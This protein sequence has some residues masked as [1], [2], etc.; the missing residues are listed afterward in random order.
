MVEVPVFRQQLPHLGVGAED[1]LRVTR[2]R[3]P[4]ERTDATAEHRANI[5]W[6]EA[7]EVEGISD[8]FLLRH[9]ADVVAVVESGRPAASE[10]EHPADVNRHRPLRRR[11]H[12]LRVSL[13]LLPPLGERPP[14]R[15]VAVERVVGAGLVGH[16]VRGDP[17]GDQLGAHVRRVP[18]HLVRA[19]LVRPRG[20]DR[21]Q[22][23]LEVVLA[24][25]EV[26]GQRVE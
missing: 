18:R 11:D 9:L 7:R 15:Q 12:G 25:H 23:T 22:Q 24:L 16:H 20:E 5:G 21:P 3:R 19:R 13:R 2:Q 14:L 4:A 10:F 26:F 6:H 1:V 8:A 17:A